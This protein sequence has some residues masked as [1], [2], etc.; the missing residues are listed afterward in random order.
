MFLGTCLCKP[1][2]GFLF[3]HPILA[4]IP[5]LV[6]LRGTWFKWGSHRPVHSFYPGS[7]YL[8]VYKIFIFEKI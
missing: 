4:K 6:H 5:L 1:T 8:F 2:L 3:Y 7:F